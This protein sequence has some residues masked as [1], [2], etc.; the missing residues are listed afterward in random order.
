MIESRSITIFMIINVTQGV[1]RVLQQSGRY[2]KQGFDS[3]ISEH[4]DITTLGVLLALI[5]EDE[6]RAAS[7]LSDCNI[8]R[9]L[10]CDVFSLEYVNDYTIINDGISKKNECETIFPQRIRFFLDGDELTVGRLEPSLLSAVFCAAQNLYEILPQVVFATEHLLYGLSLVED[11]VGMLLRRHNIT[12][13]RLFE[14]ICRQEGID[15]SEPEVISISW[16]VPPENSEPAG[17]APEFVSHTCVWDDLAAVYRILDA[18]ANRAIEAIRVLE[19]YVRFGLDN[20]DMVTLT[21]QMRHELASALRELPRNERLTAR[22]TVTDVGTGIEG[23][24]EYHRFSLADVLGANFSRLQ[25]SLRSLEEYGKIVIPQ[26]ARTA[27]RLRYQ[28]YTLQKT[29]MVSLAKDSTTRGARLRLQESCLYVL[30]DCRESEA[31]FTALIQSVMLGGADVIQLRDKQVDERLLMQRARQLRRMTADTQTLMIV[32]DRPDIALLS[33]A[34]GVHVGQEELAPSDVRQL[35]GDEMLVGVSTH[36]IEQARRAVRDG[37]D[38]LGA[39]PVFPSS[40]KA[41]DSFPGTGFLKQIAEEITLPVFAIGGISLDTLPRV[42]DCGLRRVAAQSV[43]TD[44]QDPAATCRQLKTMLSQ[45]KATN[46]A[47]DN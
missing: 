9:M 28:S 25:E 40:T 23:T 35:V 29:V 24:N 39:G 13:E 27:E 45:T 44:S 8:D 41:F 3:H 12:P 4:F 43:V 30:V 20:L 26:L 22:N 36:S 38:Y 16:D 6:C 18:S 10:I 47:T 34:D 42:I 1:R 21:K 46:H 11:D 32:N 33:R 37:A 17:V 7:W 31:N 14:Q 15:T 19:D 2:R 5:D